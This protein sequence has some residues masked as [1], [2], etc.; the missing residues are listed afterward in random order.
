MNPWPSPIRGNS[1]TNMIREFEK[2]INAIMSIDIPSEK[3]KIFFKNSV[4]ECFVKMILEAREKIENIKN[5][6][7]I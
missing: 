1:I 3:T 7:V 6:A 4:G 5:N 2:L